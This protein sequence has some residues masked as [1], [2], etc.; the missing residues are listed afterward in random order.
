M[1][2]AHGSRDPMRV[3]PPAL[4]HNVLGRLP[5]DER[6]RCACVARGWQAAVDDPALWTHLDLSAS[7]TPTWE[8]D[9]DALMGAAAR[10]RGGLVFLDLTGGRQ[11]SRY[12]VRD[13]VAA[14]GAS[15][16][17]LRLTELTVKER[18]PPPTRAQAAAAAQF[19]EL[20]A[21]KAGNEEALGYAPMVIRSMNDYDWDL[22]L[23]ELEALLAAVPALQT[24]AVEHVAAAWPVARL[25]L[26]QPSPFPA[27]RMRRLQ[28]KLHRDVVDFGALARSLAA[29][30]SLVELCLGCPL[31]PRLTLQQL[32]T[33]VDAALTLR[34]SALVLYN[35]TLTPDEAPALARL[36][37][38]GAALTRLVVRVGEDDAPVRLLDAP[39]AAALAA[40]L[41]ANGTLQELA[42]RGV[43]VLD[44]AADVAVP[45]LGAL[46]SH[47][48]LR[49]LVVSENHSEQPRDAAVGAA[50]G[51]LVAANAPALQAL[52]LPWCFLD[53]AALG[54]LVDALPRNTHLHK[55][56]L[57][58][59]D[60]SARFV[61]R[62]L[63]PAVTANTSLRTLR[64]RA[65]ADSDV[66]DDDDT[67]DDDAEADERD[68]L[69]AELV[70]RARAPER[71]WRDL[72]TPWRPTF[73]WTFPAS[74]H[75][76]DQAMV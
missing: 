26:A 30:P 32:D 7:G 60:M 39:A 57:S 43:C 17:E 22:P 63:L 13:V 10:A 61:R 45:L 18:K 73:R 35:S 76:Y 49:R 53:D 64:A 20:D 51:A 65:H 75:I 3:L 31:E 70:V 37:R 56:T 52:E 2:A 38:S 47:A 46:T 71:D 34:L 62:R 58:E 16:R 67:D 33:V 23:C 68:A 6:A 44:H 1:E 69:E 74:R 21:L 36:L 50:L 40:A 55:L 12:T 19:A 15:L 54:P 5:V 29:H 8:E 9:D 48:S 28:L 11:V 14:N 42:L 4:V 41:R 27:L 72:R 59:N 66:S 25:L 24:L